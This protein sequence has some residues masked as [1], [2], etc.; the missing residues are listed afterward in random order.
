MDKLGQIEKR[1]RE[2]HYLSLFLVYF[3][4]G[5]VFGLL[6]FI[7]RLVGFYDALEYNS[8]LRLLFA[9]VVVAFIFYLTQRERA[10]AR[11]TRELIKD[12]RAGS[13]RLRKELRY[14]KFTDELKGQLA[15]LRDEN[16]LKAMFESSRK[17]FN[18][19]GGAVVLKTQGSAWKAPLVSAPGAPDQELIEEL[20]KVIART[21]RAFVQPQPE[22]PDHRLIKNINSIIAVPLRLENRLYGLIAFWSVAETI[23]DPGELKMLEAMARE[24]TAADYN[25]EDVQEKKDIFD[26]L[27]DLIANIGDERVN[28]RQQ[29]ERVIER[30][31]EMAMA[32]GLDD[33]S[34]AS[35]SIAAKL[36]NIDLVANGAS[37]GED[38]AA[39]LATLNFPAEIVEPLL[40]ASGEELPSGELPVS[41]QILGLAELYVVNAFPPRGRKPAPKT[42]LAKIEP[43]THGYDD[44]VL[45]A[46]RETLDVSTANPD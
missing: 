31:T 36:R 21:G 10:Q 40:A 46:L 11:L 34:I 14:S 32:L 42:V 9:S 12:M 19:D 16:A 17:F 27:V 28:S 29:T 3:L 1:R 20:T 22:F 43:L 18:A 44:R 35:M 13:E 33:E 41:A 2:L 30:A 15:N 38:A 23:Y 6:F 37:G 39:I 4:A 24:A 7:D 25:L 45:A 26:G 5:V 8:F